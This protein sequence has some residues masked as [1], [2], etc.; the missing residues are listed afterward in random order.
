MNVCVYFNVI[1]GLSVAST[2]TWNMWRFCLLIHTSR[3]LKWA[4]IETP[5]VVDIMKKFPA[6]Y[7][8]Q[9]FVIVQ[10]GASPRFLLTFREMLGLIWLN[11]G[12]PLVYC[13]RL[14]APVP[15][16]FQATLR[17]WGPS[18]ST[19]LGFTM[20]QELRWTNLTLRLLMSYIYIWSTHSWCF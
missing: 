7:V 9:I 2:E 3:R 13:H 16:T 5:R 19:F 8:S 6:T 10:T 15:C 17:S 11:G 18:E 20:L 4:L 14:L 1:S 12:V